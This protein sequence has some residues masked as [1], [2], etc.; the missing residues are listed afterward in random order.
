MHIFSL[1][2]LMGGGRSCQKDAELSTD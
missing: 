2:I 1:I